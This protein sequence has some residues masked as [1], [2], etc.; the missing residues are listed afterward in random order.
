MAH[1]NALRSIFEKCLVVDTESVINEAAIKFFNHFK[2]NPFTPE[3]FGYLSY[4]K[5]I[6]LNVSIDL[7]KK[8][9]PQIMI[10]LEGDAMNEKLTEALETNKNLDKNKGLVKEQIKNLS[11]SDRKLYY[12]IKLDLTPNEICQ[13]LKINPSTFRQK[14][15]RLLDRLKNLIN[16]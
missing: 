5:T 2:K 8:H 14:K 10:Y 16:G 4:H 9:C 6:M 15:K 1:A 12:L 7:V 3:P 13:R 11:D